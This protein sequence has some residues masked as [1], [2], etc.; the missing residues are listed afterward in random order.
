M[1][2]LQGGMYPPAKGLK[3]LTWSQVEQID[4]LV[5][6]ICD[7]VPAEAEVTIVIKQHHPRFLKQPVVTV[8]FPPVK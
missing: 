8:P 2:P 1:E 6:N 7:M 5:A 3:K 4:A